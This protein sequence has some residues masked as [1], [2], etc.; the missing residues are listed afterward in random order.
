MSNQHETEINGK[1]PEKSVKPAKDNGLF[2]KKSID[3]VSSPEQ[4]NDYI[5]VSNPGVWMV[6]A[7]IIIL[8]AGV[9]V[10]GIFGRLDTSLKTLATVKDGK[11][12]CYVKEADAA[13]VKAGMTVRIGDNEYTVESVSPFPVAVSDDFG[14]YAL[15]V[16]DLQ[17]GQWVYSAT[18]KGTASDGIYEANIVIDS[19]SPMSFVFN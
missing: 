19:V 2:R 12:T 9:C 15:H 13:L 11:V 6:L 3:R 4:L 5:R 14:E 1:E 8:L 7:A 16:G 17:V 18:V 10:W